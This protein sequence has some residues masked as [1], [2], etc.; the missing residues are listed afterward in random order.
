[1][2]R[3]HTADEDCWCEPEVVPVEGPDGT[4]NYLL[5]HHEEEPDESA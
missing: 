3:E 1:M 4:I 5:I 2:S